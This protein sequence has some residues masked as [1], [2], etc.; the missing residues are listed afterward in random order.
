MKLGFLGCGSLGRALLDGWLAADV[1]SPA[2]VTVADPYTAQGLAEALGVTAGTPAEVVAASEVVLL[3]VKPHHLDSATDGLAF[4]A[5]QVVVSVLAGVRLSRVAAR[6]HPATVVRVMPNIAARVGH[7]V[8]F[9]LDGPRASVG[10]ALFGAVGHVEPLADEDHF[11]VGTALAGSGPA[12]LFV[13]IEALADAAVACGLPRAAALRVAAHTVAGAGLLAATD[14]R[15]PA[16]L[17][18][19]VASPGGTTIHALRALEAAGFRAA[20]VEAVLAAARRSE[21]LAES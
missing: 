19:A 2:D 11:H 14:G 7:A 20:L 10:A 17:K 1:V 6:V 13:A 8:T 5:A 12:Y 3:G 4:Q 18:D 9:V 15:H 16:E 21:E